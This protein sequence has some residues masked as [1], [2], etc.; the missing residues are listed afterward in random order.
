MKRALFCAVG[1]LLAS[2]CNDNALFAKGADIHVTPDALDFGVPAPGSPTTRVVTISN[3]GGKPLTVEN[4]EITADSDPVYDYLTDSVQLPVE[5]G[6]NDFLTVQVILDAP[7]ALVYTGTLLVHST[8]ADEPEVP[9][10][11][12]SAEPGP[13]PIPDIAVDPSALHFGDVQRLTCKPLPLTVSNVGT[14][15]L[16]V[17]GID[18]NILGFVNDYTASPQ[19][20]T[21]VP[22]GSE[23]VTV[24]FC[25]QQTGPQIGQLTIHSDDPDEPDVTVNIT[26]NGTPPPVSETDIHIAVEWDSDLTDLD[27]H[28]LGPGGTFWDLNSDCHWRATSPDWG[29]AGDSGD[30]PYLDVD[31]IDGFGPENINLVGPVTGDYKVVLHYYGF[32]GGTGDNGPT[33][34]D[35]DIHLNGSSTP[36]ASFSTSISHHQTWEV[37]WIHW[38]ASSG[39]GTV[40]AIDTFGSYTPLVA[41]ESKLTQPKLEA[42]LLK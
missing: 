34:A 25:P 37:A 6:P 22:A 24:E 16:N 9:V 19:S 1:L 15:N 7:D 28:L 14:G 21:V 36:T 10:E 35:L 11:L 40:E 4:L 29:T 41:L 23:T 8:D 39:T 5:L 20:F 17:S 27:L 30:D 26:G 32:E 2:G 38:D 31:D 42:E 33:N 12:L 3:E 18:I 13:D